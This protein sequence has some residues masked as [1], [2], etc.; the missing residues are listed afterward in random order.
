MPPLYRRQAG[1]TLVELFVAVL[2]GLLLTLAV[3]VIQG[4]LTRTNMQLSDAGQRN[5]Q[6]RSAIDT[7]Q[8]DLSNAL[9]MVNG[10]SPL[11]AATVQYTGSTGT[12]VISVSA[13][14]ALPQPSALPSST[15]V[16]DALMKP[17]A[18]VTAS[19]SSANVS[20]MLTINMVPTALRA[21]P[22]AG[23]Q[24]A[25]YKVVHNRVQTAP[26]GQQAVAN[27]VLPLSNI[28][29]MAAGDAVTLMVP[30][31]GGPLSGLACL[32]FSA[33]SP[34]AVSPTFPAY[35]TMPS[36]GK[37]GDF[38]QPLRDAGLLGSTQ[39][40]TDSQL[41]AAK[42]KNEGPPAAG[43]AAQLITYYVA[44]IS[45]GA[46]GTVPVLARAVINADGTLDAQPAPVA[47]GVV[48]LQALF[49]VDGVSNATAATGGITNYRTWSQVVSAQIAGRVRSV[50]YAVV[51]RTLQ[52]DARNPVVNAVP[53]PSPNLGT[54]D[55]TFTP[56]YPRTTDEQRDRY[57]VH[58]AEVA[59]R[60]QI[61]GN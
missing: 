59:L 12:P 35:I 19:L 41:V 37:F 30:M 4:Q 21:P 39:V 13:V 6:A 34:T 42:L 51:T 48:G 5:D 10:T 40:L 32:R 24:S 1:F 58:V 29:G 18:Y 55:P 43:A 60:N 25:P 61:W 11:C 15:T 26:G 17:D 22:A 33:A 53:I 54:G 2:I 23:V 45:N 47:V 9:Y 28:D 50:L 36:P 52:T 44:T 31:S 3:M 46:S 56:F 27:G 49:G 20:H 16:V 57:T 38:T 8:R 14:E 7:L